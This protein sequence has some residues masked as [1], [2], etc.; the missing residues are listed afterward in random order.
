M[1]QYI[2]REEA[3]LAFSMVGITDSKP[4][5]SFNTWV[6]T[7]MPLKLET[8]KQDGIDCLEIADLAF[9]EE[10]RGCL[11]EVSV[12]LCIRIFWASFVQVKSLFFSLASLS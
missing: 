9:W 1:L 5:P 2:F 10:A 12:G 8:E 4:P 3:F 6:S 11:L 7:A